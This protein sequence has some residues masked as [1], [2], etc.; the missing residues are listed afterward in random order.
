MITGS[1]G[2]S[3]KSG[4]T[5]GGKMFN[6]MKIPASGKYDLTGGKWLEEDI[7]PANPFMLQSATLGNFVYSIVGN[8]TLAR[9]G[10]L[11]NSK[12]E[13]VLV[14]PPAKY[15]SLGLITYDNEIYA[16]GL[17]DSYGFVLYKVD[18]TTYKLIQIYTTA[19]TPIISTSM[20]AFKVT[21]TRFLFLSNAMIATYDFSNGTHTLLDSYNRYQGGGFHLQKLADGN[22]LIGIIGSGT[23]GKGIDITKYFT[24]TNTI[25]QKIGTVIFP[26]NIHN[27]Q[28]FQLGEK[29][30]FTIDTAYL[31]AGSN[32]GELDLSNE[33][34]N[35][36][37]YPDHTNAPVF[38]NAASGF[39]HQNNLIFYDGVKKYFLP[40]IQ[41]PPEQNAV[42]AKIYK[43][44]SF[45]TPFDTVEM[46]AI[47]NQS[48]F[49]V[50]PQTNKAA[51]DLTIH[52]G[53][54]EH[55]GELPINV[56]EE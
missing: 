33:T 38:N 28:T 55:I 53:Q 13:V 39:I 47:P 24:A 2:M 42:V 8:T 46:S 14:S 45:N 10:L 27:L 32:T 18:L 25:T 30:M 12:F 36:A 35:P 49:T 52:L 23:M 19:A 51:Q 56:W 34:V 4:G 29:L 6:Q 17:L 20:K 26:N 5:G 16:F 9:R 11:D 37:K 40:L 15:S 41:S 48:E 22:Y 43:G 31:Q 44:Q 21:A 54:Y 3:R 50:S 7:T 1:I